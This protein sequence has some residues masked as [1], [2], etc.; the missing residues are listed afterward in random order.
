MKHKLTTIIMALAAIGVA[1][2]THANAANITFNFLENGTNIDLGP[3]STFTESGISLTAS[4][5]L[6]AGGATDLFAKNGG[7]VDMGLGTNIDSAHEI[8]NSNFIQLT[9][10]TMPPSTFNMVVAASVQSG[11]T[12]K[13]F[14]TTTPGT[15]AG[16]TLL[17]TITTNFG[18]VSVPAGDQ[19]GFIDITEGLAGS[20]NVLVASAQVTVVPEP[21]SV[22]F[23]A[24]GAGALVTLRRRFSGALLPR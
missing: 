12:A 16:A 1:L 21:S 24:L 14:F 10:P 23:L 3:S 13:V 22:A 15:L 6:T 17:G 4:G 11:S 9:L 8:N 5:F 18:S 20:G 19:S 2:A 7:P